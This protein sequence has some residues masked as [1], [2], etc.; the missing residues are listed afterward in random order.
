[1]RITKRTLLGPALALALFTASCGGGGNPTDEGYAA[2]GK[3]DW[4]A[5]ASSFE[6]ALK[7][8]SPTD[9]GFK[10]AKMGHVEALIHLDAKSSEQ[11]F[12][13]LAR[14]NPELIGS[15]EY[16]TVASK[17]TSAKQYLPAIGVLDAGLKANPEDPKL[18]AVLEKVKSEAQKSNDAGA[19][20]ALKG[21][22]YL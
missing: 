22:G 19:L 13:A 20:D 2:L 15:D 10:R 18:M 21:L 6:Q 3:S 16:R 7:G 9:P 8:L 12:L 4:S 17:M 5:A 14:G 11:E 1:M